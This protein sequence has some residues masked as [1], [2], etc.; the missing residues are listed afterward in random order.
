MS[1]FRNSVHLVITLYMALFCCG[2]LIAQ[3]KVAIK[4]YVQLN[5]LAS[6]GDNAPFWLVSNRNGMMSLDN[7]NGY[8]GL[9]VYLL[10]S[11]RC[12]FFLPIYSCTD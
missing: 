4:D 6:V 9:D 8:I 5:A 1:V 12:V 11:M 10:C 3:D 7:N 2:T